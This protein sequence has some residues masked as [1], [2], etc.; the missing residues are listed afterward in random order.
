MDSSTI[1]FLF[2]QLGLGKDEPEY[3]WYVY[4]ELHTMDKLSK[5][6]FVEFFLNPPEYKIEDIEDI[7]NLFQ[8]FDIKGKGSFG[9]SEFLEFFKFSPIYQA[10]PQLVESNLEKSFYHIQKLYGNK[11][12]TPIEFFQIMNH[13]KH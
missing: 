8:I 1:L 6:Q 12:I 5:T 10:D 13:T 11:E 7:K 3:F 4:N 2:N 9:K